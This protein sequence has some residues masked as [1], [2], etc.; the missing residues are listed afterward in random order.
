MTKV[1]DD[2]MLGKIAR[3]QNDLFRRVREGLD[4]ELVSRGIQNLIEGR[5]DGIS[6]NTLLTVDYSVRPSLVKFDTV[7]HPDRKDVATIDLS[8]V[9]RVLTLREDETFVGGEENLRR[10]K[11]RAEETGE[12]LLDV[13]VL[14]ELLKHPHLIPEEWKKGVTYFLGTIFRDSDGNRYVVCLVGDGGRW[15]WS[16]RWLEVSWSFDK[17]AAVLCKSA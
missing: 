7:E 5:F 12:T 8:K 11:K 15:G 14:E 1:A 17:F 2:A 3:Q 10:L 9:S 13:R 4:P 6:A 16:H